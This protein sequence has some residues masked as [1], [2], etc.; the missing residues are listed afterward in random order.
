M[1]LAK[2]TEG[3]RRRIGDEVDD[4]SGCGLTRRGDLSR[5]RLFLATK[6]KV[7]DQVFEGNLQLRVEECE[8]FFFSKEASFHFFF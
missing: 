2:Q 8:T 7:C 6:L 3:L 1:H 5:A 4:L